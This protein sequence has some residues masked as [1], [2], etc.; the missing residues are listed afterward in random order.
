LCRKADA[1]ANR[2]YLSPD[3]AGSRRDQARSRGPLQIRVGY[4]KDAGTI[5]IADNGAGMR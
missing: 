5:T 4:D 3:A 2:R 1:E